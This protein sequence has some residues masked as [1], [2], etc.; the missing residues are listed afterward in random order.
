MNL[1]SAVVAVHG[2]DGVLEILAA[3]CFLIAVIAAFI[4]APRN[5]WAIGIA[6]GLFLWLLSLIFA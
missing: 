3:L 6:G 2:A 4:A 1:A 5:Y